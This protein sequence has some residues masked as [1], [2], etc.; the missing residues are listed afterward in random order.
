HLRRRALEREDARRRSRTRWTS[1][2]SNIYGLSEIMGPGVSME[3]LEGRHG[4]AHLRGP[5]PR[6][7]RSIPKPA[8]CCRRAKTGELVF[9]TITKEAFPLIRYRTRDISRLDHANPAGAAGRSH[10]MDRVTG[11][12]DDMLIIRGVNVFPSQIEAVL[13]GDRGRGT[14]LPADRGPR[15][16]T[17]TPWRSRWRSARRSSPTPT[18]SRSSRTWSGGSSRTSRT[19]WASRPR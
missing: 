3:C 12:S 6:R 4:H 1:R 17:S 14:P 18:R 16:A 10:R 9:T 2:R 19:T 8:R 13:I 5:L 15:P 11:R 7:D